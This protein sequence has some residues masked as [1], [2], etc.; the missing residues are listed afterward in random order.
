MQVMTLKQIHFMISVIT[1]IILCY[2]FYLQQFNLTMDKNLSNIRLKLLLWQSNIANYKSVCQ[3][4]EKLSSSSSSSTLN[5][6]QHE[7]H[8]STNFTNVNSNHYDYVQFSNYFD[9]S[10]SIGKFDLNP[11]NFFYPN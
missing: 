5:I 11:I 1:V 3:L 2:Y 10:T 4:N 6:H 8:H 7:Y 9:Q